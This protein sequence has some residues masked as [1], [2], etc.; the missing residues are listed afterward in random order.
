MLTQPPVVQ[1]GWRTQRIAEFLSKEHFKILPPSQC[2]LP[3]RTLPKVFSSSLSGSQPLCLHLLDGGREEGETQL[4]R[5]EGSGS[6]RSASCQLK[7]CIL[8]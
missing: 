5:Y 8:L 2:Q 3:T 1:W 4:S 6:V 7:P